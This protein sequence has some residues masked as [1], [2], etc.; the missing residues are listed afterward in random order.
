MI[1]KLT[2][3]DFMRLVD[4]MK[5]NYGINSIADLS[6]FYE[7]NTNKLEIMRNKISR[8][9]LDY[10]QMKILDMCFWQVGYDLYSTKD[11]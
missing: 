8:K 9:D 7:D 11:K 3:K 4:Y 5:T 2:D 1:L 10:P 6:L